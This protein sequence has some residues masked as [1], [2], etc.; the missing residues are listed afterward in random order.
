MSASSDLVLSSYRACPGLLPQ[1][2]LEVRIPMRVIVSTNLLGKCQV[3]E[4]LS[5]WFLLS[6]IAYYYVHVAGLVAGALTDQKISLLRALSHRRRRFRQQRW[7]KR[8]EVPAWV[9]SGCKEEA[10]KRATQLRGHIQHT[11]LGASG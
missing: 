1:W 8:T 9:S 4:P 10:F 2:E 7:I 11:C 5:F 6:S 3:I